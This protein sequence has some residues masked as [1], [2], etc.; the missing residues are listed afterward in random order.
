MLTIDGGQVA[1][2]LK[3]LT[4]A[5]SGYVSDEQFNLLAQAAQDIRAY[6]CIK[7]IQRVEGLCSTVPNAA[8]LVLVLSN[9]P[10]YWRPAARGRPTNAD[11]V[12]LREWSIIT[13]VR[14][15]GTSKRAGHHARPRTPASR[16]GHLSVAG[17]LV[18]AGANGAFRYIAFQ[19]QKGAGF[20]TL[21]SPDE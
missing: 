5:W 18:T 1:L 19:V 16:G 8:G 14:E 10:T 9:D 6:D 15:W 11:A 13:V 21:V 20:D 7:D 12:R 3:H 2:E 4:A 17:V